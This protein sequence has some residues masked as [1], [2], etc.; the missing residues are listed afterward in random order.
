MKLSFI[1]GA[2]VP[3]DDEARALGK[4]YRVGDEIEFEV[5]NPRRAAFNSKVFVSLDEIA[6]MLDITMMSLRAEILIE[7]GRAENL[8]LR[9]GTRVWAVPSMSKAAM[10]QSELESFWDDART[11]ILKEVMIS[12]N[13][14]QQTRVR[15]ML[16]ANEENVV[17]PLAGG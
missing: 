15:A 7:T 5:I 2:L 4:K 3:A 12:L 13:G 11:Y 6:K 1:K 17:N 10:T 9:D 14:D 8:K 16:G